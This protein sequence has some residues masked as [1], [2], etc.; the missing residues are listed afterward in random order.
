MSWQEAGIQTVSITA[1]DRYGASSTSIIQ[2]N[3]FDEL[4]LSW[5][6]GSQGDLTISIDTTEH[7]SNPSVTISNVGELVLSEISVFWGICNSV[8][9]I[10]HSSGISH[11]L[12]PFIV[13]HIN[14][15]GLGSGDYITFTVRAV[16]QDG[17]DR[18][19]DETYKVYATLPVVIVDDEPTVKAPS[20]NGMSPLKISLIGLGLLSLLCA[21]LVVNVV[22]R[23]RIKSVEVNDL[24]MPIQHQYQQETMYPE[25]RERSPPPPPMMAQLPP[26]GLPDGWTM[27]QWHYYGEEYLRRLN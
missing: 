7:Y 1:E 23:R 15:E 16:D 8:T 6:L 5:R 10:C 20:S 11:N 18:S 3:I 27:E 26:G 17:M 9:G 24:P 14:G 12:G 25:S 21:I 22:L 2:V 19:T 13:N 4:P